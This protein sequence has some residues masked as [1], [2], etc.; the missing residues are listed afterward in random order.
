MPTD[1]VISADSHVVEPPTLWA[2]RLDRSLRDRAPAVTETPAGFVFSGGGSAVF[3]VAG[4]YAAG[5]SGTELASFVAGERRAPLYQGARASG[6]DPSER[7]KD[8]D[9]DGVCAEVLYPSLGLVLFSMTD[10][11]LQRASFRAY[12]AWLAEFVSADPKRMHGIAMVSLEDMA[13]AVDTLE[14]AHALGLKGAMVC[15]EPPDDRPFHSDVYDPFWEAA[16]ALGMP[17]SLHVVTSARRN[18]SDR[19]VGG[20]FEQDPNRRKYTYMIGFTNVQHLI[21]RSLTALLLG[22]TFQRFPGLK[23]VSAEFDIGWF[24]HFMYRIDHAF[25]KYR[26]LYRL[27]LDLAPSDYVKRNVWATFQDDPIG[28]Q[29]AESYGR[30]R[31][32]WASDFPHSDSTWPH[33]RQIIAR[34]LD[35]LGP[36]TRANIAY[37]NAASLY[38]IDVD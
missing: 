20:L 1:L 15:A 34:D 11:E 32:M 9:I 22:G 6:W 21:Q 7:L 24:P 4:G 25:E 8:Q 29:F 14:A 19:G 17:V 35:V 28:P 33:S 5:R 31:F 27:E 13:D 23:V 30:D 37:R 38:R 2:E 12:N 36:A 10:L 16:E 18:S 3:P 26:E